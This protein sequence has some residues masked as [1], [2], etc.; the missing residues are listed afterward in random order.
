MKPLS[1]LTHLHLFAVQNDLKTLILAVEST[2]YERLNNNTYKVDIDDLVGAIRLL[3]FSHT[4]SMDYDVQEV[5]LRYSHGKQ[6]E[7][8]ASE[9]FEACLDPEKGLPSF[10]KGLARQSALGED[11]GG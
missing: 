10:I 9:Q 3:F 7:L 11:R 5:V 6:Q 2:M 4:D 1:L 8:L